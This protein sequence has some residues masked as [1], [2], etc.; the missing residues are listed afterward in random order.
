MNL[1][2]GR[3]HHLYCMYCKS[4][5]ETEFVAK[6][7]AL[8]QKR[9]H[10]KVNS[11]LPFDLALFLGVR[12]I[13][14]S[15][16]FTS[17]MICSMMSSE[18]AWT[19]IEKS[20]KKVWNLLATLSS[21]ALELQFGLVKVILDFLVFETCSPRP[22][23]DRRKWT[24][25]TPIGIFCTFASIL[26]GASTLFW[27]CVCNWPVFSFSAL[28]F[29]PDLY[30]RWVCLQLT[31][32]LGAARLRKKT[33]AA[34]NSPLSP[35]Y[36]LFR[37][38]KS[39]ADKQLFIFGP[40]LIWFNKGEPLYKLTNN[41][42]CLST[43]YPAFVPFLRCPTTCEICNKNPFSLTHLTRYNTVQEKEAD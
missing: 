9:K 29:F 15:I 4:K 5:S 11:C 19:K 1:H 31:L 20:T 24:I 13:F 12:K 26:F 40:E 41:P 18:V 38:H 35:F 8:K 32:Q 22:T 33:R 39:L 10:W 27:I 42:R 16:I 14:P 3:N 6:V 7:F 28:A 23:H 43:F 34:I 36:N 25:A 17:L 37:L 21:L 30:S 2:Q